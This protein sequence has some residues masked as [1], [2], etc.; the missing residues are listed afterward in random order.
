MGF[1]QFLA[2]RSQRELPYEKFPKI[3]W[4]LDS[5]PVTFY[6]GTHAR[7]KDW[8]LQ[9]GLHAPTEGSTAGWVSLAIEPNTSL[10]YASMSG[11]GGETA[12]RDASKTKAVHTPTNERIVFVLKI[13]QSEFLNKMAKARGNMEAERNKLTDR[14][15]YASFIK[16]KPYQFDQE[17]YAKTEIRMPKVVDPKYIVGYM[18]KK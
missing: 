7:N 14:N 8:I 13:P 18:V 3:G 9:N 15:K 5:D 2:E 12:F 1:K 4:W 11:N 17:Y 16:G 6:H 10:G